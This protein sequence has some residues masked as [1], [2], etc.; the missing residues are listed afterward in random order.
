MNYIDNSTGTSAGNYLTD[1]ADVLFYF[2]GLATVPNIG[3]NSY[4]AGAVADHLTSAGGRLTGPNTQMS[5]LRWLEAGAIASYGTVIEPCNFLDKFTDTT[6]FVSSYFGGATVL[7]AY[8]KSIRTPGEGI[9]IGD[10]LTRPY[11]TS[12]VL[13]DDGAVDILTTALRPGKTYSLLGAQSLGESCTVV[14]SGITVDQISFS[15]ISESSGDVVYVLAED[16]VPGDLTGDCFG[17]FTCAG[18]PDADEDGIADA[19]DNCIHV[20]NSDQRDPDSDGYGAKCDADFNQD[21]YT[22]LS[23][24]SVFRSAFGSSAGQ[25]AFNADVDMDGSG[26]V[27]LTDFSLFRSMFGSVPGPSCCGH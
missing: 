20:A 2:T 17:T 6:A 18:C 24:F 4:L 12:V 10:P 26:F 15:S 5:S 16:F 25:P 9:F 27:N 21:G 3:T 19:F 22:N 14:R 13:G 23:D 1:T 11:G 8:W 7:E